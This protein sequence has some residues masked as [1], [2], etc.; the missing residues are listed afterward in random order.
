[1]KQQVHLAEQV[2]QGLSF[3][4]VESAFLETREI[5]RFLALFLEMLKGFHQKSPG[6]CCRIKDCFA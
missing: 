1:M 2:R 4:T 6:A 3:D 5:L